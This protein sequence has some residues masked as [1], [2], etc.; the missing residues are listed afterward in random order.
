M[1]GVDNRRKTKARLHA[2]AGCPQY[3]QVRDLD[4]ALRFVAAGVWFKGYQGVSRKLTYL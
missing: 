1:Y 2:R 4:E 3:P